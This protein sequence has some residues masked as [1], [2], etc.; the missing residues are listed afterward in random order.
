[1]RVAAAVALC[2][3]PGSE[4]WKVAKIRKRYVAA[5]ISSSH[6]ASR[7]SP[8]SL[9]GRGVPVLLATPRVAL[10]VYSGSMMVS[11]I[12]MVEPRISM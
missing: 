2:D 1:L 9:A 7:S 8:A 5:A 12:T 4:R 3:Q 10:P 11:R 6:L